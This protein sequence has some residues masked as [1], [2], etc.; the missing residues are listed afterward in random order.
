MNTS[1]GEMPVLHL[2]QE[3]VLDR[4]PDWLGVAM[5]T[6]SVI[7]WGVQKCVV[8]LTL[9][10]PDISGVESVLRHVPIWL[11][12]F[13]SLLGVVFLLTKHWPSIKRMWWAIFGRSV[14]RGRR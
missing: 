14:K 9:L 12:A 4:I 5:S 7:H 13:A 6:N 8:L 2:A 1:T 10:S 3:R 11:N